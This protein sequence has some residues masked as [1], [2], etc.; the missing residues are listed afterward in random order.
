V[1]RIAAAPRTSCRLRGRF[2]VEANKQLS[3]AGVPRGPSA[4]HALTRLGRLSGRH[5]VLIVIDIARALHSF[6]AATT[7]KRDLK[8]TCA[9]ASRM[10]RETGG[11][12][13]DQALHDD[14]HLTSLNQRGHVLTLHALRAGVEMPRWS[15]SRSYTSFALGATSTHLLTGKCRSHPGRRTRKSSGIKRARGVRADPQVEPGRAATPLEGDHRQDVCTAS[16][17]SATSAASSRKAPSTPRNWST[18]IPSCRQRCVSGSPWLGRPRRV[19]ELPTRVDHPVLT[20]RASVWAPDAVWPPPPRQTAGGRGC[21][22][23]SGGAGRF[24]RRAL[25]ATIGVG[26]LALGCAAAG[27]RPRPVPANPSEKQQHYR[28]GTNSVAL[29]RSHGRLRGSNSISPER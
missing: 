20:P 27:S 1:S 12:R 9:A 21:H 5:T 3:R 4:S 8:P 2:V 6:T 17:V 16:P 13:P 7:C 18:R 28:H 29:R 15:T 24:R 25:F 22:A 10:Y 26:L 23:L 19:P 11:P 14:S